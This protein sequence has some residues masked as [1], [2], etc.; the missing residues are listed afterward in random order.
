MMEGEYPISGKQNGRLFF[1]YLPEI[2]YAMVLN[3][4]ATC[5][6][7]IL[8]NDDA[9]DWTSVRLSVGGDMIRPCEVYM[10]KIGAGQRLQLLSWRKGSDQPLSFTVRRTAQDELTYENFTGLSIDGQ[11]VDPSQYAAEPGSVKLTSLAT[12]TLLE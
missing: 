1:D 8:Q 3:D 5:V 11:P 12:S 2:N 10:E 4:V 7:C 9:R 6:R